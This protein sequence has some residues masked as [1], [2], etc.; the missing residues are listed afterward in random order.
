MIDLPENKYKEGLGFSPSA[1]SIKP[2]T[3][4]EP[5]KGI[6]HSAGFIHTPAEA[7]AIIENSSEEA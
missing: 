3:V 4:I 6:F 5:I 7:N 2:S 1:R